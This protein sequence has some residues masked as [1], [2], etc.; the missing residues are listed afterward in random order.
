MV[1]LL[2]P[3]IELVSDV[4]VPQRAAV[5]LVDCGYSA[6]DHLVAR[7]GPRPVAVVDHHWDAARDEHIPFRDIRPGVT[8]CSS[9]ATGYLRE[10]RLEIDA[11]LATALL[12]AIRTET[13]GC[14]THY[15]RLDRSATVWLTRRANLS[16]I[17]EIEN[18]TLSRAYFDNLV[19]ALQNT[20]VYDEA[21]F[22]LLPHAENAEIVGEVA[23]L[24]IRC[25]GVRRVL[26]GAV[27]RRDLVVSVRTERGGDDATAL[28]AKTLEGLGHGGGHQHR[29][30]GK[31]SN[32]TRGRKLPDD[33]E[34]VLKG[35][36]LDACGVSR[37]RG[38]RLV[39][40]RE[41][42]GNL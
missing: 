17:A 5:V 39:A 19:L 30:G 12:Y 22:C 25:Q 28:V 18:A 16:R 27:V 37:R 29:A 2:R 8:A 3:P 13:F 32:V 40:R 26:C 14:Q 33:F 7:G 35:R 31:V 6:T 1:E 11:H 23:D 20:F 24:L 10:H 34:N 41:I 15:S 36:W 42:L 21:A 38:E 4:D 9:I